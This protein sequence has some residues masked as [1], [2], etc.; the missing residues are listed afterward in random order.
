VRFYHKKD[1][2][3]YEYITNNFE[4]SALQIADIYKS[5]REIEVLF[6]WI[7]QNLKIKTFL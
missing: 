3:V 4:L 5:R 6:R 7:K 2:R 1:D